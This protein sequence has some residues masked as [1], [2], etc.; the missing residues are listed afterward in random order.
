MPIDSMVDGLVDCI[1]TCKEYQV[2][3][4]FLGTYSISKQKL[5]QLQKGK[6]PAFQACINKYL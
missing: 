6:D 5:L 2:I 4:E 1:F 3:F